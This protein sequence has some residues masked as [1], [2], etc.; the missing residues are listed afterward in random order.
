MTILLIKNFQFENSYLQTKC[1]KTIFPHER[2]FEARTTAGSE[3]LHL[4][5]CA[6]DVFTQ[7]D[8]IIFFVRNN[9]K[10]NQNFYFNH[11]SIRFL[12]QKTFW[13]QVCLNL[14]MV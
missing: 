11:W 2:Y 1:G 3:C 12:S 9:G 6:E 7:E 10:E 13:V 5:E 4:R 14:L 8:C